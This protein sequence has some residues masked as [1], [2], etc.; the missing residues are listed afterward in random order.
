MERPLHRPAPLLLATVSQLRSNRTVKCIVAGSANNP[1]DFALVRFNSNG[2]L[3]T[4]FD[5]DGFAFISI[6][7][8][9]DGANSIVIEPSGKILVAGFADSGT[10]SDFAIVRFNSNGSLDSSYGIAG[11]V[12]LNIFVS[13]IGNAIVLDSLGRAVVAGEVAECSVL[14]IR[15]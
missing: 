13:D 4:S 6:G 7:V 8:G 10:N 3:D 15:N 5:G 11:K 14:A 2:S 1:S 9:S 12:I